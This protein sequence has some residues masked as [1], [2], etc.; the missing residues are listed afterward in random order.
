MGAGSY[1]RRRPSAL[2]R[3][4]QQHQFES[5]RYEVERLRLH[6]EISGFIVTELTDVHWECNG[7]LDM[8]RAPKA[9]HARY[10]SL[11]G[12]DLPI[13]VLGRPRCSVGKSIDLALFVAHSSQIDLSRCEVRWRF[14]DA[15]GSVTAD[16]SPW[17]A[18]RIGSLALRPDRVG[19]H[20]LDLE[21]IDRR[22]TII[23]RNTTILLVL[24]GA[25]DAGGS[26]G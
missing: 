18:P 3:S 19:R 16:V 10:A 7:L 24:A 6:P 14:G 9:G 17:S 4:S 1:L 15:A 21:L 23:G 13:G 25:C 20:E 2:W 11:F 26:L 8:D 22:G 12:P 5:L